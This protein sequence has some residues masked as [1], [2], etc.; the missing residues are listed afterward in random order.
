METWAKSSPDSMKSFLEEEH[1]FDYPL[2]AYN[3]LVEALTNRDPVS[4]LEWSAKL[5]DKSDTLLGKA[6]EI[7]MT[8]RPEAAVNWLR[9]SPSNPQAEAALLDQLSL[10]MSHLRE[11]E[12]V[13]P[14]LGPANRKWVEARFKED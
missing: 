10:A 3:H 11:A 13:L 9:N 12:L 14:K 5:G 4:A 2:Q 8:K 1:N 7:W 6:S